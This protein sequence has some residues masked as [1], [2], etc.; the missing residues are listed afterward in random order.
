MA[1][2]TPVS[3]GRVERGIDMVMSAQR[4]AGAEM[5]EE[6]LALG[7]QQLRGDI[8]VDEAVEAVA[9]RARALSHRT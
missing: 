1:I 8:T 6:A 2:N 4:A 9:A 7:R 5:S 3:E